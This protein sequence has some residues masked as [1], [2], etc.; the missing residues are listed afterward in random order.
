MKPAAAGIGFGLIIQPRAVE[1]SLW[2][3]LHYEDDLT[4]REALFERYLPLA[5]RIARHE[6]SR[7]PAYGLDRADFEQLAF[8]GL[9]ESIDRFDPLHGA[10]FE[11]YA[12]RRIRGAVADGIACSSEGAAQFTHRQR[13]EN[14]RLRSLSTGLDGSDPIA[15]LAQLASGL[16]VGL[17]VENA[18][19]LMEQQPSPELDA[20]ESRAWRELQLAML[21]AIENLPSQQR[22]IL[23]QHYLN[24]L[25]FTQIAKF[26]GLSRG[27]VSQ[28]HRP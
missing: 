9:L 1:A 27:R 24:G 18:A 20:Y 21:A 10:P 13:I 6:F 15:A 17:V 2:R 26:L 23:Q 25:D 5:R 3:R 14:E 11:A 4:C 19:R 12:R 8:T 16:A 7:R 28:L 22:L